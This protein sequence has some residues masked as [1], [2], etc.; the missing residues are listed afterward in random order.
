MKPAELFDLSNEVAVV[1]G[2]TGALGGAL[3][4]GLASA[5]AKVAVIGRN[6]ERG[7]GRVRTIQSRGGT[8]GFFAADAVKRESLQAAHQAIQK[9]FGP[10][11]IL[12]NAAGGNDSKVTVTADLPFERIGLDD[13]QA[14]YD[15]NVLGGVV[16]PCQEFGAAMVAR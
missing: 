10:P 5:G 15:L 13:W 6:A 2:A 3:A 7:E 8:G 12:V 16:L 4:E 1:I 9:S 14:N 11:T